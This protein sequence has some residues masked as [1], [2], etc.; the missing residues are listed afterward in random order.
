MPEQV[1]W[2]LRLEGKSARKALRELYGDDSGRQAERYRRL[3]ELA[4]ADVAKVGV[5]KVG[6]AKVGAA[7]S[8]LCFYSAPGRT[9][10]GGNHTDH[11]RGR[12]LCAAV[13]LDAVACVAPSKDGVVRLISEGYADP[14]AVDLSSLQAVSAERGTTAALVR[15]VARGLTDYLAANKLRGTGLSGFTGRLSSTVLPGSGLSSSAAIEVLLGTIMADLAGIEVPPL[16]IAKIGQFAENEYFGKPCGLMDQAASAVGGI[17]AIDFADPAAPKLKRVKF[18]FAEEGYDL[19]VVSTGGS[20][21]DLTADYAAVPAEMRSVA[22]FL[23]ARFLREV[24]PALLIARGPGI[25]EACGDRAFLRALHF[26]QEN[27]RVSDM[28]KALGSGEIGAYLKLVRS[29]GSSSWRLLQ[30]LYP[31]SAPSE[32]GL[33]VALALSEEYLGRKG[34]WRVHGGGFAGTIQAYVPRKR[35]A[36]YSRLMEAFFGAGSVIPVSVRPSGAQRVR[37]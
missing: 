17:V 3:A 27:M 36:G 2:K 11:N 30:N 19:V 24:D 16:E 6:V 28:A 5:A 4:E 14:I 35:L 37:I 13:R 18:D 29:S 25:R 15:G 7:D 12:V 9:E 33:P 23:G 1:D 34:A 32:Q 31:P 21:A 8:G 20:H 10:L 22:E 26:A